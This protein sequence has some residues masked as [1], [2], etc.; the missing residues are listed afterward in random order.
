[1]REKYGTDFYFLTHY[2]TAARPFYT[3]VDPTD[4][5]ITLSYDAFMRGQEICS[6][7]QRIHQPD[8]LIAR[9]KSMDPPINLE[10]KGFQNYIDAF[11]LGCPPHGGGG[12]GLNRITM[13]WLG[14]PNIRQSTLFPRD[15]SRLAP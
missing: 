14:L 1:M 7:A 12:F 13:L 15:P 8:A 9:M 6:G 11:R 3:H 5:K 10:D 2:P 4:P